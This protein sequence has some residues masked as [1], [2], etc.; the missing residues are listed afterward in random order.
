[1][2]VA[3]AG[4]ITGGHLFPTLMV[5]KTLQAKGI[6][7]LYVGSQHGLESQIELPLPAKLL[8]MQGMRNARKNPARAF[9]SFRKA[10]QQSFRLLEV[11]G[12][13]L[14][15]ATG[16]YA[17]A[18]VLMAQKK[19]KRPVMLLEADALPGKTN[20]WLAKHATVVCVNFEEAIDHFKAQGARRVV[21]TGLPV[22]P[23]KFCHNQSP[24]EAR[25]SMGLNPRLFTVLVIGGSQGAQTL[26]DLTLHTVQHIPKNEIQWVHI[27]GNA[28]YESVTATATRLGLNGNYH[29]HP[30]LMDEVMAAAYRSA[31]MALARAGAGSVTEIALNA[32]PAIFVP[33][34][35]LAND[36]QRYNSMALVTRN[37]ALM[38]SQDEITPAKLAQVALDW[39]DRPEKRAEIG[40]NAKRWALPNA[41]QT[42]VELI[43][44]L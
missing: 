20:R 35:R 22:D 7:V 21:R 1:M 23:I 17:A 9:L 16:G 15:F 19:R 37:A 33:L 2:K 28:N 43:E 34:P 31:D 29:V 25:E 24:G 41:V 10:R 38:I 26:N 30:F 44:T 39:R 42:I 13:D 4:G 40:M 3:L 8:P 27:T 14:V 6:E 11:F 18:P 36:H 12:A 32:L 5:G